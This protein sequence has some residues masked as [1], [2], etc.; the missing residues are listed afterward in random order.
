M[1]LTEAVTILELISWTDVGCQNCFKN[2][3]RGLVKKLPEAPWLNAASIFC[4]YKREE[5]EDFE[6]L[7]R[8]P[9]NEKWRTIATEVVVETLG[10]LNG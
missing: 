7:H 8:G 9:T 5:S 2:V 6:W 1:N 3:L 10:G 4:H